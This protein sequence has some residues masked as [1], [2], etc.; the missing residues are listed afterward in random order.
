M[1]LEPTT[2][3]CFLGAFFGGESTPNTDLF[4]GDGVLK[5]L[6]SYRASVAVRL[7]F[8]DETPDAFLEED[9]ARHSVAE[10]VFVPLRFA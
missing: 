6:D 10:C 4:V 2:A 5:A 8:N 9:V 3:T 1:N 7:G